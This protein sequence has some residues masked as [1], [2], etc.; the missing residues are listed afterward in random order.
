MRVLTNNT[1]YTTSRLALSTVAGWPSSYRSL[2]AEAA[3]MADMAERDNAARVAFQ[4]R[5][6][7]K[8]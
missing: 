7:R 3:E 5:Q 1:T 8:H 2:E 4:R 6:I